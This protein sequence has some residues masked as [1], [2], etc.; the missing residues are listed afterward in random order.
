M[1][2]EHA[3]AVAAAMAVLDA[4][5]GALNARDADALNATLHFPHY[6]LASDRLKVWEDGD[7]YLADFRARTT[8]DWDHSEWDF[9]DVVA[10]SATKVHLSVQFTRYRSDGSVIGHYRSLWVVTELNGRWAA[11]LRSSFA[12]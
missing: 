6:R 11:Q 9:R 1:S 5:M 12:A 8:D 3:E 4:H 2:E 10:A 7:E